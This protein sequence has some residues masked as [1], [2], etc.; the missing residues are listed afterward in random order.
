MAAIDTYLQQIRTAVYGRDVRSAIANGIEECYNFVSAYEGLDDLDVN[1]IVTN[2]DLTRY[3]T[4]T[5]AGNTYATLASLQ[6]YVDYAN[7]DALYATKDELAQNYINAATIADTYATKA[8]LANY[9]PSTDIIAQYVKKTDAESFVKYDDLNSFITKADADSS[10]IPLTSANDYVFRSDLDAYST[11]EYVNGT[12]VRQ[13]DFANVHSFDVIVCGDAA[14]DIPYGATDKNGTEGSM[15]PT[16][17]TMYKIYMV[18]CDIIDGMHYEKYITVQTD[19]NT[20]AW[21][22][23]GGSSEN[24]III[25]PGSETGQ[26]IDLSDYMLRSDAMQTFELKGSFDKYLETAIAD[27]KYL[28]K[29]ELESVISTHLNNLDYATHTDLN[30]YPTKQEVQDQYATRSQLA[31]YTTSDDLYRDYATKAYV[32]S[33]VVTFP[34]DDNILLMLEV[35]DIPGTTQ[36]IIYNINGDIDRIVHIRD[37][38]TY[39]VDQFTF[40]ETDITEVRTLTETGQRLEI[41]TNTET[42]QT[43]TTFYNA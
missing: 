24:S 15:R 42:S 30:I 19:A 21:E 35:D 2:D 32:D 36:S 14:M 29:E 3:L 17:G 22:R 39:R 7:A 25:D 43:V 6:Q 28:S 8:Q 1:D 16:A 5:E 13:T 12:F 20:F 31:A 37:G 27:E 4:K 10:Y 23:F 41:R 26:T 34:T 33:F 18:P 40:G 11:N 9:L 38:N